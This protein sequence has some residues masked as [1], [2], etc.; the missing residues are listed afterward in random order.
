MN[1]IIRCLCTTICFRVCTLYVFSSIH[2]IK[3]A[4]FTSANAQVHVYV[5]MC[6][7]S[8]QPGSASAPCRCM[9]PGPWP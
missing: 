4:F 5:Y 7:C 3:N 2:V 1:I 6:V 8:N 9:I